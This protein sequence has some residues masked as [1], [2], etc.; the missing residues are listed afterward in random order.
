MNLRELCRLAADR[1][2]NIYEYREM[3][4]GWGV[5]TQFRKGKLYVTDTDNSKYSFSSRSS[6]PT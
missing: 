6:M 1:A 4:E 3:L 5:D 2:E